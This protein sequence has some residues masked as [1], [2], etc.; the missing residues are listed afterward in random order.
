[1]GV[2]YPIDLLVCVA[3][4]V[5][6][7]DCVYPARTARFGVALSDEGNMQ[8]KQRR[9]KEDLAP[10]EKDCKCPTCLHFTRAY[11]HILA[12]KEQTGAR[13]ITQHNI[14]YMMRLMKRAR[15]AI[16]AGR[17]PQFVQEYFEKVYPK[18]DYPWWC[19]Q[20]LREVGIELSGAPQERPPSPV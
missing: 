2:G 8:L 14:A 17:Y 15:E 1:M 12:A 7:F 9:F 13:L 20:A 3:L 4:G 11:L 16:S 10:L 5:D 18:H 6:M 19:V